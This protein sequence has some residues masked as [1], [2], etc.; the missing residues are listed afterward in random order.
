[1]DYD[2][3][4]QV[5]RA[6]KAALTRAQHSGD[7]AKI[8]AAVRGAREAFDA[9]GWPD[10]WPTWAIAVRDLEYHEEPG[11]RAAARAEADAW[12]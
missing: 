12:G 1:M 11:I 4:N 6:Q 5:K 9:H 2:K 8:I 3:L 7:P 10:Q